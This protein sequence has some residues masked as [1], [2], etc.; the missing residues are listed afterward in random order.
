MKTLGLL[1]IKKTS[2]ILPILFGFLLVSC[3]SYHNSSYYDSD[4]IYSKSEEYASQKASQENNREVTG[5]YFTQ[6]QDYYIPNEETVGIFTDVDSYYGEGEAYST[7]YSGWGNSV[8][9][10]SVNIY[11]G[12]LG[13]GGWYGNWGWGSSY[14]DYGW[15]WNSWYTPYWGWNSWHSPYW[16]WNSWHNPYWGWNYGWGGSYYP[17]YG[18]YTYHRGPRNAYYSDYSYGS[19][20]MRA[21]ASSRSVNQNR[22]YEVRERGQN[23]TPT[24]SDSR[25]TTNATRTNTVQNTRGSN[26]TRNS[27][28]D[29]STNTRNS[30]INNN[31]SNTNT[32]N[33]T[34]DNTR[35]N[36]INNN[37]SNNTNNRSGSFNSNRNN[38]SSP[39]MNRG[40][41]MGGGRS[42]GM[43]GGSTRS[44][45]GGRR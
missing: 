19:R 38:S 45:S 18:G 43:G 33:N 26:S 32:R 8:S 36:T 37:R 35:N 20:S 34:I 9:D 30:T 12:G 21:S 5:S 27:T 41:N 39:S 22:A 1:N 25:F 17:Y 11:G 15:G 23:V 14:W 44:S 42:S 10:V 2:R 6:F 7:G 31:R 3:G 16:G 13:W 40:G 29:N 4:G 24:R 28:I